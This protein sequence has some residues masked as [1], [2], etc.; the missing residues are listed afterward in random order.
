M[1]VIKEEDDLKVN[2]KKKLTRKPPVTTIKSQNVN[3][4]SINKTSMLN[5]QPILVTSRLATTTHINKQCFNDN[6]LS[7]DTFISLNQL[8]AESASKI[9]PQNGISRLGSA[10]TSIKIIEPNTNKQDQQQQQN[11][12][13]TNSGLLSSSSSQYFQPTYST[14][15][16]DQ[17]MFNINSAQFLTQTYSNSDFVSLPKRAINTKFSNT[18]KYVV[19]SLISENLL[20]YCKE[21]E[22]FMDTGLSSHML[23]STNNNHAT[24]ITTGVG[25]VNSLNTIQMND[26]DNSSLASRFLLNDNNSVSNNTLIT[27]STNNIINVPKAA[28]IVSRSSL[29]VPPSSTTITSFQQLKQKQPPLAKT[30]L[31]SFQT[32]DTSKQDQNLKLTTLI[33]ASSSGNV[34]PQNMDKTPVQ[35]N[36][37][38]KEIKFKSN[39]NTP[40]PRQ[41]GN[42]T[43]KINHF[44]Q[45]GVTSSNSMPTLNSSSNQYKPATPVIMNNNKAISSLKPTLASKTAI[46][47]T[48]LIRPATTNISK[49]KSL[50]VRGTN[51]N[52]FQTAAKTKIQ[53]KT[54]SN[55]KQTQNINDDE[56][57]LLDFD[58]IEDDEFSYMSSSDL[59]LKSRSFENFNYKQQEFK[60]AKSNTT[61][62]LQTQQ[63]QQSSSPKKSHVSE[64][65]R[66][67]L[68]ITPREPQPQ[69]A[70]RWTDLAVGYYVNHDT[71][72]INEF[73]SDSNNN[74]LNLNKDE[75]DVH[76]QHIE[77]VSNIFKIR[78]YNLSDLD[79]LQEA[80][81]DIFKR[82]SFV[83]D[84]YIKS[85]LGS[86]LHTTQSFRSDLSSRVSLVSVGD[87]KISKV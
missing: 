34:T 57:R 43:L 50:L 38:K 31:A 21:Y 64:L 71:E 61:P 69:F 6:S 83:N 65:S 84:P 39:D 28:K 33:T 70:G 9:N 82:Y 54:I 17:N 40:P 10:L 24:N 52:L 29:R 49:A 46:N 58:D 12:L 3:K 86:S 26:I 45:P 56:G 68:L 11:L 23:S 78:R 48:P 22:F 44:K 15:H 14:D 60:E 62:A 27:N 55:N 63:R 36:I 87:S 1:E 16:M 2:R 13:D 5:S 85:R 80:K 18:F 37:I 77:Y 42:E 20:D 8:N 59:A 79:E 19:N 51:K 74:L 76:K 72:M 73:K 25:S 67:Q 4:T 7:S 41:Q 32:T 47:T 35:Q 75:N 66:Q 30:R 53:Q 81:R